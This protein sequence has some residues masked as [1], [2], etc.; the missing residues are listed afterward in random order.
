MLLALL[1]T[2]R[3]FEFMAVVLAWSIAAVVLALLRSRALWSPRRVLAGAA[4]FAVVAI[5]VHVAT[6]KSDVFVLY[7]SNLDRQS[8]AVSEAE[9][10]ETPPFSFR[11]VPVKLVQLFVEPCY[12]SLCSVSDYDVGGGTSSDLWSL[13][14]AIQLPALLLIPLCIG[15]LGFLLARSMRRRSFGTRLRELRPLVEM[16]IAATGLVLGYTASTLTGPS[17]LRYGFARDFL[18]PPSIAIVAATLV[19]AGLWLVLVRRDAPRL[20]SVSAFIGLVVAGSVIAVG[21]TADAGHTGS[22]GSKVRTSSRCRTR[23]T[24]MVR[25]AEVSLEASN[26]SGEAVAI[27]QSSV[28]TFGC[29]TDK[30]RLSVYV[31]TLDESVVNAVVCRAA[32]R[33][34]LADG[35]GIAAG[36]LRA[37]RSRRRECVDREMSLDATQH[38]AASA[39]RRIGNVVERVD[40]LF[41]LAWI[42]F[43]LVLPVSGWSAVAFRAW[44]DQRRDLEALESVISS[45][46]ADEIA[47][48]GIGPA[49]VAVA[50]WIHSAFGLA[51]QD[52]LVVLTRGSYVLSIAVGM[53]LVRLAVRRLVAAPAPVSIAAQLA[54]VALVV[55]AG[56]WHW[57]DV[58]WSHFFAAFSRRH[59][60]CGRNVRP[61]DASGGRGRGAPRTARAHPDLRS[62]PRSSSRSG[63]PHSS[64]P[65]SGSAAR[66]SGR[67]STSSQVPSR[68]RSRRRSSTW[69]RQ[70]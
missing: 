63:S 60:L 51:P 46:R 59:A 31:E 35:H 1:A 18:P 41:P 52:A 12:H 61:R 64:S 32:P 8:A 7:A 48:S 11:F 47:D 24:A 37:R 57:S 44:F 68:L 23:L 56:T 4:A 65:P 17:H 70:A 36:Q 28:L 66:E 3:T 22:R 50:A 26:P 40:Q 39:H 21:T 6:G 62:S 69:D 10:A 33:R 19:A 67:L 45:G 54:F 53:A 58:P 30:A 14:L 55:A 9:V 49:Y 20:S 38:H 16:T 5:G 15:V 43:Y 42:G 29:G 25:G 34:R 27:P 2:T 13:P